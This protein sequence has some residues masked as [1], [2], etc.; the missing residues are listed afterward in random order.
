MKT[1]ILTL[2][3]YAL[4]FCIFGDDLS[5]AF[6]E[7]NRLYEQQKFS[8]AATAYGKI[9]NGGTISSAL[10]FNLGNA[11]FK[12]GQI[13]RA[14]ASFR[15]AEKLAPRDPDIR[16]NLRFARQQVR[17][18]DERTKWG[19][20]LN[21]LTLEEWAVLTSI[22]W[23]AFFI[24]LAAIQLKADWRRS[25]RLVRLALGITVVA[26]IVTF[27]VVLQQ[28]LSSSAV[29]ISREATLRRGPFA[30]S[31]SAFSARDGTELKVLGQHND[32]VQVADDGNRTGW[33]PRNQVILIR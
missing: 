30:E 12:A 22:V 10:F 15:E 9:I 27:V 25:T 13:G 2:L 18:G 3:V 8:D 6:T 28:Q 4:P 23:A 33:I 16:A 20:W 11:Q 24:S 26:L 19:V 5:V 1:I 31:Q 32:W 14:I 21:R 17:D 7:A 29:I